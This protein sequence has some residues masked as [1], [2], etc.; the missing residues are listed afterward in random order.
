MSNWNKVGHSRGIR[1]GSEPMLRLSRMAGLLLLLAACGGVGEQRVCYEI[2]E[3][4][5]TEFGARALR[6][7][8]CPADE[9]G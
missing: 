1:D 9:N 6:P 3:S 5:T 7:V 4:Q 8:P 2:Y